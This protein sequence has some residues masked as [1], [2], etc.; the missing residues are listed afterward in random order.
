[1][2]MRYI[3]P[4]FLLICSY[5]LAQENELSKEEKDSLSFEMLLAAYDGESEKVLDLLKLGADVNYA[6]NDGITAIMY[7]VGNNHLQTVKVLAANG[8]DINSLVNAIETPL[9]VAVNNNNYDISAYL[10][11]KGADPN[12]KDISDFS[13]L[14]YAVANQH[15]EITELLLKNKAKVDDKCYQGYTPLMA[16]VFNSDIYLSGML[17][18]NNANVNT[19]DDYGYT[20]LMIAAQKND[21]LMIEF[22]L[23][24]GADMNA[25]N[26]RGSSALAIAVMHENPEAVDLLL[27]KGASTENENLNLLDIAKI[28]KDN[29]SASILKQYDTKSSILPLFRIIRIDYGLNFNFTD[30]MYDFNIS[31]A[32]IKYN[33]STGM[34]YSFR[35]GRQ[36][37]LYEIDENS[38]YQLKEWRSYLYLFLEKKVFLLKS[39]KSKYGLN[40]KAN[41]A[42]TFGSNSGTDIKV[43]DKFCFLP[44][45]GFYWSNNIFGANLNYQYFNTGVKGV[46]KHRI[47]LSICF[48]IKTKDDARY[49]ERTESWKD[50]YR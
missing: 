16:A 42:Y 29:K 9:I 44:E 13:P 22:L 2:F 12:K 49:M 10:L 4:V 46:S 34:G 30:F 20:P 39:N 27:E 5:S 23:E 38:Y 36:R 6:S 17:L 3:I 25:Q 43:D 41:G 35:I 21:T 8:A 26:N 18:A 1:M 47:K 45:A 14:F 37:V 31:Y 11:S 24:K 19:V 50:D 15:R 7:A 48:N 33:I 40:F 32:D 28:N